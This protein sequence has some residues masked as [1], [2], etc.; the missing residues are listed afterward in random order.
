MK[1]FD[2]VQGS[3]DWFKL[4]KG[5]PTASRFDQILTPTKG[6]PSAK[7]QR[8][9]IAELIGERLA[10]IPPEGIEHYTNRAM[11]WGVACEEE[12]RRWY[13]LHTDADVFNGGF[14]MDN[15]DKFGCSPDSLLGISGENEHG[16]MVLVKPVGCLEL[17]CPQ[18][19]TMTKYLLDGKLPNAYRWQCH[20][21]M[22]VTGTDWVDFCAYCPG[23]PKQLLIRVER[24][25]DTLKLA[26]ALEEFY[27]KF[28][29]A[30]KAIQEAA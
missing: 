29:A 11:R 23:F 2:V 26:Q 6:E 4:R 25:A 1:W 9:L 30:L 18:P 12:G 28:L 5:K 3:D 17:K 20:G 27:G 15:E 14:C 7:G 22:I 13:S 10:T 19:H 16:E 24:G 21:H 8:T